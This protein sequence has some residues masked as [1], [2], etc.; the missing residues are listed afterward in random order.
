M[1]RNPLLE[2]YI[3][4][5]LVCCSGTIASVNGKFGK[6][7][8]ILAAIGIILIANVYFNKEI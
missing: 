5:I 8:I 1:K 7:D 4:A 3:G 6:L 2:A